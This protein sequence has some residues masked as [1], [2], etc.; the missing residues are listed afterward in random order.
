MQEL[1][2]FYNGL[3]AGMLVLDDSTGQRAT[4]LYIDTDLIGQR[5]IK[6]DNPYLDGR[7]HPWEVSPV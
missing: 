6:L 7:R 2:D 4:I 5:S 3:I 1:V